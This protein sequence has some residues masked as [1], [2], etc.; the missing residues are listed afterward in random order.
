M[1]EFIEFLINKLPN[2]SCLYGSLIQSSNNH[3]YKQSSKH[4]RFSYYND[5]FFKINK[6]CNILSCSNKLSNDKY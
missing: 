1:T 2:Y 4:K 3:L 6:L 5:L